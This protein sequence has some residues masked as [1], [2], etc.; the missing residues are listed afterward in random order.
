[1]TISVSLYNLQDAVG[2]IRVFVFQDAPEFRTTGGQ[3]D[4]PLHEVLELLER[5][6][7]T[8]GAAQQLLES[9]LRQP[10]RVQRRR[11][12]LTPDQVIRMREFVPELTEA[13]N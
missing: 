13:L 4:Q 6:G 5:A 3:A 2:H 1:M 12:Q 10:P 9:V 8:Q 7:L 11:L